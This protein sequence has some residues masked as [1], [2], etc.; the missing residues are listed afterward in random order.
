MFYTYMYM[1]YYMYLHSNDYPAVLKV[2]TNRF[3]ISFI[4]WGLIL[5]NAQ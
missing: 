4:P 3:Q 2:R 1:M 5:C